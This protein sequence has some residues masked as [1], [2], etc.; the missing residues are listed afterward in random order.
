MDILTKGTAADYVSYTA[1]WVCVNY[2]GVQGY[3]KAEYVHIEAGSNEAVLMS[4]ELWNETLQDAGLVEEPVEEVTVQAE[5][6]VE[7]PAPAAET[8][9]AEPVVAEPSADELARQRIDAIYAEGRSAM[10]PIYL[11]ADEIYLLSCV[12]MMEAGGEAYEGKLAVAGVV[13][14]RL[15][16]GIWGSTLNEVIYSPK[17][18]T[19]AGTG[20]LANILASGPNEECVRAAYEAAAGVHN[21]GG[22]MFFCSVGTANYGAYSSYLVIDKQC[23]YAR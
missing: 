18:F 11:N 1:G 22:Y 15:R 17:Q 6:A 23:F 16:S 13:M 21:I 3:L 14:N 2:N 12:I 10:A 4:E 20:L 8:V 19:G 7:E 5:A 9:A